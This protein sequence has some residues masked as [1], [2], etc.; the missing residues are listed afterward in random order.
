MHFQRPTN[1]PRGTRARAVFV[2]RISCALLH[3]G[4]ICQAEVVIGGKIQQP[5]P[6]D[7]HMRS[8]RGLDP[9][10]L[11]IEPVPANGLQAPRQVILERCHRLKGRTHAGQPQAEIGDGGAFCPDLIGGFSKNAKRRER[12]KALF[13]FFWSEQVGFTRS[14]SE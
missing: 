2:E 12:A 11:P 10:H 1:Q 5:L 8:L 14:R 3:C 6:F 7:R 4:M 13:A 9:A